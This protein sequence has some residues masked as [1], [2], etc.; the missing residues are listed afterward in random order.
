[1]IGEKLESILFD[2]LINGLICPELF[3]EDDHD[4]DVQSESIM[5][6]L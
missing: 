2:R 4:D 6:D 1:M 5:I 3:F